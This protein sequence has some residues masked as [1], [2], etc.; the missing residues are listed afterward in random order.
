MVDPY[1]AVEWYKQKHP[2]AAAGLDDYD[3]YRKIQRT[4]K[5]HEYPEN[6]FQV[7]KTYE[8]PTLNQAEE[9][10]D[11]GG[12]SKLSLMSLAEVWADDHDWAARAYNNSFAGTIYQVIHGK[13]K[14]QAEGE[15]SGVAED[16]GGFFLGLVSPIDLLGF[17]GSGGVGALAAKGVGKAGLKTAGG[18]IL[19]D[20]MAKEIT[21]Q[22]ALRTASQSGINQF[23]GK[24]FS[25]KG[26]MESGVSLATYGAAA[27]ALQNAHIGW[28]LHL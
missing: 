18:K 9:E 20:N 15:S 26:A 16:I 22:A 13:P 12:L 5:T 21:E 10:I 24:H 27:G 4:Y 8:R 6:P 3:I 28:S 7:K 23:L 25:K 11:Q 14:Y 17:A 1:K 19:K 2:Y